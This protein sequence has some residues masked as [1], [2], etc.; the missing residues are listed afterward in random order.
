[1]PAGDGE[2]IFK[3]LQLHRA[4]FICFP[5][6]DPKNVKL[7]LSNGKV[8]Y[9]VYVWVVGS[10]SA[11]IYLLIYWLIDIY[12]YWLILLFFKKSFEHQLS[13]IIILNLIGLYSIVY[14][15]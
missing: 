2:A 9:C 7:Y 14:M 4:N 15:V 8:C 5:I 11:H 10:M 6:G 12:I 3:N 13:D 1:M